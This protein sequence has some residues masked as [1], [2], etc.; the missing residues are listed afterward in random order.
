M[1]N[2]SAAYFTY[3]STPEVSNEVATLKESLS[4]QEKDA[5]SYKKKCQKLSQQLKATE[6]QLNSMKKVLKQKVSIC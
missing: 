2:C 1:S 5:S 4:K 3:S 6:D